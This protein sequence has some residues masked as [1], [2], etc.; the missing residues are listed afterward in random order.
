MAKPPADA[1]GYF[2]Q[3]HNITEKADI[4]GHVWFYNPAEK[5]FL[6]SIKNINLVVDI[7]GRIWYTTIRVFDS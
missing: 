4:C 3:C 5:N 2:S 1:R 6:K 7:H